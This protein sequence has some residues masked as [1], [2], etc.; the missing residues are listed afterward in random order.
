MTACRLMVNYGVPSHELAP[1]GGL[2]TDQLIFIGDQRDGCAELTLALLHPIGRIWRIAQ[3]GQLTE[4]FEA[5]IILMWVEQ[6]FCYCIAVT[7]S[8]AVHGHSA[9]H[10][11]ASATAQAPDQANMANCCNLHIS[12]RS[13]HSV[14]AVSHLSNSRLHVHCDCASGTP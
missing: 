3:H 2:R 7:T 12:A 10:L 9:C 11:Q 4:L 6:V 5:P 1:R 8:V 14:R 13:M